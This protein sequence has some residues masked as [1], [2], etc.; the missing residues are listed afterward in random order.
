MLTEESVK[1]PT[2]EEKYATKI[3]EFTDLESFISLQ[4]PKDE[5]AYK[6]VVKDKEEFL[7]SAKESLLDSKEYKVAEKKQHEAE[8]QQTAV[9]LMLG[10]YDISVVILSALRY[11]SLNQLK[12]FPKEE[13]T[14]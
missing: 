8:K 14:K 7:V 12:V 13:Q 2:V 1:L 6:Q 10:V 11:S 4:V 9:A 5:D 3:K